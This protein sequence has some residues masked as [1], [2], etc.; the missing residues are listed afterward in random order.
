MIANNSKNTR[1]SS[2]QRKRILA[3]LQES[4][5]HPTADWIYAQ[6]KP[7]FPHLSLG[8]VYRNLAILTDQGLVKKIQSGSTFDRFEARVN[9]HYH[10]I[11]T[12]CDTISDL[13][14]P[15]YKEINDRAGRM[16]DFQIQE[17]RIN[18]YGLCSSCR[19]LKTDT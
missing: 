5:I 3:L 17:H 7:E 15:I 10:L 4:E 19:G 11:C 13:E 14:L 2:R 6:L 1:R 16:T 12:R 9:P 18:F 8:T